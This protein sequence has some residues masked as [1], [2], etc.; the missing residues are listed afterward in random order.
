M[1]ELWKKIKRFLRSFGVKAPEI[2]ENTFIVWEPCSKSHAEVVPG[3]AEY[4]LDSGYHV[5]VLL[6]NARYD[7]GLFE[8]F[9]NENITFN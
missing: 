2:R 9:D 6:N 1:K 8:R 5:S 7:E 4:L 3:F